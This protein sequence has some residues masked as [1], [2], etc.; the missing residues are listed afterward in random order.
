MY[1]IVVLACSIM[2]LAAPVQENSSIEPVR[3]W[4]WAFDVIY[5]FQPKLAARYADVYRTCSYFYGVPIE[6]LVG[7]GETETHFDWRKNGEGGLS[8]GTHQ[9]KIKF[10]EHRDYLLTCDYGNGSLGK[11]IKRRK[12]KGLKINWHAYMRRIGYNTQT[13]SQKLQAK[14][15]KYGT[16]EMAVLAYGCG[17]SSK[18][19]KKA[20]RGELNVKDY[21]YIKKTMRYYDK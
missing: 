6:I 3:E 5:K 4:A 14:Y 9:I 2:L 15:K 10:K 12:S 8:Y 16:W 21:W 19:F 11:I 17:E 7:I 20:K 18:I 13:A 1:K